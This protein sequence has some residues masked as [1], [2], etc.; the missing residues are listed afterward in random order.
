MWDLSKAYVTPWLWEILDG[1]KFSMDA[2]YD[3]LE[4][5]SD[6]ELI[7]YQYQFKEAVE[8]GMLSNSE[9][10]QPYLPWK[11]GDDDMDGDLGYWLVSLGRDVWEMVQNSPKAVKLYADLLLE[12]KVDTLPCWNWIGERKTEYE[13]SPAELGQ[14]ILFERGMD[15]DKYYQLLFVREQAGNSQAL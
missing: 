5:L 6:S 10:Y 3:H 11:S 12:G 4:S 1:A 13:T 7:E 15:E 8:M 2:L 14:D 9:E